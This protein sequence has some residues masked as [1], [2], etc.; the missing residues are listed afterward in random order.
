MGNS[1]EGT[2]SER[3]QNKAALTFPTNVLLD[4]M[5]CSSSVLHLKHIA[6]LKIVYDICWSCATVSHGTFTCLLE[7]RGIRL[8]CD[9]SVKI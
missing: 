9:F 1:Y 8:F 4:D 3:I 7:E 2:C 5:D 6:L